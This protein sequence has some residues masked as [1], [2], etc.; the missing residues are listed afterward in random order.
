MKT[1]GLFLFGIRA[2]A[3]AGATV[4]MLAGCGDEK[5]KPATQ[6]AARVNK[7]EITVHQ[8]NFLLQQQ[9]G[10]RPEQTEAASKQMLERLIDQE[11]ALQKANELKLDRDPQ[12][13]QQ[14]EAAR[15]DIV[16]RAY[17]EKVGAGASKPSTEEVK[18]YYDDNPALFSQR[19]VYQLQELFV[20]AAPD[21]VPTLRQQLQDAKNVGEFVE[22]LKKNDYKFSAN[23]AVRAAEQL[24]L[25]TVGTF[26]Q[27]KDG[28]AMLSPTPSGA[29]VIVLVASRSQPVDEERAKPAIEQFLLNERKRKIVADD[30]KALRAAAKVQY[31]GKFAEGAA[32]APAAAAPTAADVAASAAKGLDAAVHE[33][34]GVKPIQS[35]PGGVPAPVAA[36]PSAPAASGI[37]T[38]TINKGLGLK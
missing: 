3:V 6:T 31:M 16:S 32:S 21:R 27:L 37:D 15:R 30:L 28:Q 8:I 23:Q 26:A 36:G 12:V 4:L 34:L 13:V 2:A 33:G 5:G 38:S 25:A 7:D 35:T 18:K 9:R 11:L 19:R 24:P 10:V 20:E 1:Q 22:Y 17:F 29:Q 14:L